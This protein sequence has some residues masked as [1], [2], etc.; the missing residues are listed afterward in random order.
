MHP[1]PHPHS[2]VGINRENLLSF[3][4]NAPAS[5]KFFL[6]IPPSPHPHMWVGGRALIEKLYIPTYVGGGAG[7]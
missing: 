4:I 2:G 7:H 5:Y 1:H 6:L 3:S